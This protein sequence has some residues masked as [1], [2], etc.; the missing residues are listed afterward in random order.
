MTVKE[1]KDHIAG[2]VKSTLPKSLKDAL[3]GMWPNSD[4]AEDLADEMSHALVTA[5]ADSFADVLATAIDAYATSLKITGTIITTGSPSTQQAR[6][7]E[8][9]MP[10]SAGSIPN[11]LKIQSGSYS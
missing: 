8:A 10:A 3:K 4:L 7:I 2:G 6:I 11:T 5:F 9:P 1:L